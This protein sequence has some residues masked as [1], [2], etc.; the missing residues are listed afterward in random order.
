MKVLLQKH[1]NSLHA[2]DE[3]GERM[4]QRLVAGELVE[5]DLRRPRNLKHHRLFYALM[6]LV[7]ANVDHDVYPT[8]DS[9]IVRMK[10][11]TGHRTEMR[12][13]TEGGFVTAYIPRSISFAAMAQDEFDAFFR[14]CTDW[15]L[16][17]VL[18]GNTNEELL[19]EVDAMIGVRST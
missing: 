9:L 10:I 1:L 11:D 5:V 17:T 13:P 18:P 4:L 16:E 6:S 7:W 15:V 8:I 3:E 12:F 2:T 19:A 14:R